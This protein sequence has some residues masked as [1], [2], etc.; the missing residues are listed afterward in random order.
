[1]RVRRSVFVILLIVGTIMAAGDAQALVCEY[2]CAL[3]PTHTH[4]T[5]DENLANSHAAEAVHDHNNHDLTHHTSSVIE[6]LSGHHDCSSIDSVTVATINQT[7]V[8]PGPM[9]CVTADLPAMSSVFTSPRYHAA[10]MGS[11][12]H[13]PPR[14]ALAASTFLRI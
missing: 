2:L 13:G 14:F 6:S 4:G 7:N 8:L 12:P 5:D 1:M 3:S 9:I 10:L 11:P